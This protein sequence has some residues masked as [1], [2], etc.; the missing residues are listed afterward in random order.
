MKRTIIKDLLRTT[1]YGAHALV[2]GWV[3]T[4]RSSKSVHFIALNDGSTIKNVQVV[5][6]VEKFDADL[7][8]QIT[9]GACLSVEGLIVESP[10]AGQSVEL[11]ATKI[12]I[13]GACGDDYPMQKKGQTFEYM[14]TH[15]PLRLRTNTFVAVFPVGHQLA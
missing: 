9:T 8:K 12:D 10:G 5:A 6:D 13:L 15:A 1:D 3:R 14:R 7:L 11:Q 4:H 2:K